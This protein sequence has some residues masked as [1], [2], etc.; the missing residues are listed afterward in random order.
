M[1]RRE[2]IDR[3]NEEAFAAFSKRADEGPVYMLNLLEFV[4]NGGA[5]R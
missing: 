2:G 4:P 5:E 3:P 1:E